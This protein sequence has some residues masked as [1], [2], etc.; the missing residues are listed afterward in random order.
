M[1]IFKKHW[2]NPS[3]I[4]QFVEDGYDNVSGGGYIHDSV[5]ISLN[6]SLGIVS[7]KDKFGIILMQEEFNRDEGKLVD[8]ELEVCVCKYNKIEYLSDAGNGRCDFIIHNEKGCGIGRV[9]CSDEGGFTGTEYFELMECTARLAITNDEANIIQFSIGDRVRYYNK[10]TGVVSSDYDRI[11][12]SELSIIAYDYDEEEISVIHALTNN[13]LFSTKA[14]YCKNIAH[15]EEGEVFELEYSGNRYLVF[16]NDEE[17]RAYVISQIR[18]IRAET[19]YDGIRHYLTRF[20]YKKLSDWETIT[21]CGDMF[22]QRDIE[23]IARRC[24]YDTF[25]EGDW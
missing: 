18:E 20:S 22:S 23:K 8:T 2:V 15:Y 3:E 21:P 25:E 11:E 9:L 14:L 13:I 24:E 10:N 17:A 4:I 16:C 12:S 5:R 7:K 6:K 1:K 19:V